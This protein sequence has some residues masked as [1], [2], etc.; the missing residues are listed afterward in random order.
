[1]S[2]YKYLVVELYEKQNA[3]AEIHLFD[4]N[5]YW[6]QKAT[7]QIGTRTRV[8]EEL[9]NLKKGNGVTLNTEHI[10]IAGFWSYG[11]NPI[12]IKSV[13]LSN[14]KDATGAAT[15]IGEVEALPDCGDNV[16]YNLRGQRVVNPTPGIYIKNGKKI[17]II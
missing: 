13:F 15:G 2:D 11:G 4:E 7:I 12:R 1:M 9:A 3:G 6:A 8:V 14:D 5:D 17:V 16:I 10:Y